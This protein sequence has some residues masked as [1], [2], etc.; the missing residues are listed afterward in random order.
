MPQDQFIIA[1]KTV[2]AEVYVFDY[3]KHDSKPAADGIC[4]PDLRLIGTLTSFI[5][6]C[7]SSA[8]CRFML[9][10]MRGHACIDQSVSCQQQLSY[11]KLDGPDA[12]SA[13]HWLTKYHASFSA[14]A[15]RAAAVALH[16][17]SVASLMWQGTRRKATVLLGAHFSLGICCQ[18]AMT[19]RSACG[20]SVGCLEGQIR[21]VACSLR[22][23]LN[24]LLSNRFH[25]TYCGGADNCMN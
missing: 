6:T 17:A 19:H 21:S 8:Q 3:S 24:C 4:R 14:A 11:C 5:G 22:Y 18:A 16:A 9:T 13:N 1:T 15:T 2:S 23:N 20:I 12:R 10:C 7:L 25:K